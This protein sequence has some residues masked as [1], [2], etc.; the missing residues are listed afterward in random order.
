[1]IPSTRF[2]SI[3]AWLE[4][5]NPSF[6][7]EWHGKDGANKPFLLGILRI[8]PRRPTETAIHSYAPHD[9]VDKLLYRVLLLQSPVTTHLLVPL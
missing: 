5:V 7:S 2:V 9:D 1:M 3:F 8:T 4:N 6:P